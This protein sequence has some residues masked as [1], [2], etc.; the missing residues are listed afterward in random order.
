MIPLN[1]KIAAKMDRYNG[2]IVFVAASKQTF[3][4]NET[5]WTSMFGKEFQL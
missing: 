2:A 5:Y 4:K 3:K 1:S